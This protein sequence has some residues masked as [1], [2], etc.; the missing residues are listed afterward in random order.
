MDKKFCRNRSISHG[1]QDASIF[2]FVP[3]FA[4]NLK[5]QHGRHF[6]RDNF[7]FFENWVDYSRYKYLCFAIFVK[8][9]KIQNGR[10][11]WCDC[12]F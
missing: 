12:I 3:I 4:K 5:I 8:I 9:S 11:F 7:F 2:V 6:W 10:H 1:F